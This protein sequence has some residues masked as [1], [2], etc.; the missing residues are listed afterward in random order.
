[1]LHLSAIILT[2]NEADHVRDCIESVRFADHI[3]VFDSGSTDGTDSLAR[4]TG[5]TVVTHPFVNY[6]AQRNAV[7]DHVSGQTDW[8][9]FV[10]ADERV[11]PALAQEIRASISSLEYAGFRI[12]RHNY[13]FGRL[14]LGAGWFP[15]YQ[16]RLL[17]ASRARYDLAHEVHEIV[18]LDGQE[19]TLRSPLVH[20]NYRSLSQFIAKQRRYAALDAQMALK[21]SFRP[22]FRQVLTLPLRQFWWRFITLRGCDDGLHGL[23]MSL[24][25]T[26]YEFYRLLLIRRLWNAQRADTP[27]GISR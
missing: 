11:T 20:H 2:Y 23:R 9:L 6:A 3:I 7:L 22:T 13:I 8:V 18:I 1:M 10:D 15:D 16:T 4:A 17:H 5:A 19:G 27:N 26:W 14:T 24:L 25:M 12:P 21:R